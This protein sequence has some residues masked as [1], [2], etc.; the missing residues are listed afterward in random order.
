LIIGVTRAQ[1]S[2]AVAEP[3][4]VVGDRDRGDAWTR[5]KYAGVGAGFI[6]GGSCVRRGHGLPDRAAGDDR[7]DMKQDPA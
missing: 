6:G 2:W 5:A 4:A 3:A 1:S 7:R